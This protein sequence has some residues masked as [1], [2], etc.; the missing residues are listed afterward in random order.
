[1]TLLYHR[2]V[3]KSSLI[4]QLHLKFGYFKVDNFTRG[5]TNY[6]PEVYTEC[7]TGLHNLTERGDDLVIKFV[8]NEVLGEKIKRDGQR[9]SLSEISRQTGISKNALSHMSRDEITRI[10]FSTLDALCEY[11]DCD[12]GDLL[13]KE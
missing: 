6:K 3:Q 2:L 13:R 10:N 9:I 4:V 12:P 11:F 1:M 7:V 8:F 5:L